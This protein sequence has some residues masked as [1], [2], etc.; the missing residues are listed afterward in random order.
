MPT[1]LLPCVAPLQAWDTQSHF[2]VRTTGREP[3]KSGII[4]LLCAALG[5]PRTESV[6]DLVQLRMGVRVDQEGIVLRDWHTA[7][8]DGYLKASGSIER[9][10]VITST[11]YYLSDA[12]FLVGLEHDDD[13]FLNR[14]HDALNHPRWLLYLGR[15]SCPP[16]VPMYLPDGIQGAD[17]ITA[18]EIYPWLGLGRYRWKARSKQ[19]RL[20]VIHEHYQRVQEK[21]PRGLR[22]V[23]EDK[24]SGEGVRNDHPL[25]FEKGN[26]RFSFR[27][28]HVDWIEWPALPQ[29]VV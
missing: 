16:S 20:N 3:S 9:K 22:I 4:G 11:R 14:L 10:N 29:E 13:A 25:S 26:R 5:R 24:D 21:N 8:I 12:A 2:G 15:K 27:R 28:I 6:E 7:G 19:D 1:L 17:L 23:L 18:L